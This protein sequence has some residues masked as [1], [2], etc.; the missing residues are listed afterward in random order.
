MSS[1]QRRYVCS[2][3]KRVFEDRSQVIEIQ[4]PVVASKGKAKMGDFVCYDCIAKVYEP[5]TTSPRRVTAV[6]P[7]C[8]EVVEVWL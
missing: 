3:C 4:D 2:V 6:C 7:R 1:G 5:P 8:G